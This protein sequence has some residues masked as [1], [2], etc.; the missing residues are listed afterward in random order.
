[1]KKMLAI[2]V[3]LVL[4]LTAACALGEAPAADPLHAHLE[5][6]NET[7]YTLANLDYG[8]MTPKDPAMAKIFVDLL[9]DMTIKPVTTEAPDGIYVVLSFPEENTRFDFFLANPEK[10]LFRYVKADGTEEM[11]EATVPEGRADIADLMSSWAY[12]VADELGLVPPVTAKLPDPGWILDSVNGKVWMDDR[13]TLEVFLEDTDNYKVLITWGSSAT[14]AVEWTY[15]C[16][17]NAENQTLCAAHMIRDS[18]VYD[19]QGNES[20]TTV[21]E[22]DV[23]TVF[24]LNADGKVVITNAGDEQL[25]GKTFEAVPAEQAE[26]AWT[27][28]ES[29][30][31]TEE[32]QAK[33][34]AAMAHLMGAK[35]TP[36]AYL[37]TDG[38]A[39]CFFC[40][41]EAVVP[42]PVPRYTL[43]Y[44][45]DS[46][47]QNIYDV[48]VENHAEK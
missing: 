21:E 46:G 48:W 23:Q 12:S 5:K 25:D 47:G 16:A 44:I 29:N 17:Y 8:E 18:L 26:S 28:P 9:N 41:S 42:N 24:A 39:D 15:G 11:Y 13:A 20:R 32:L 35:H 4:A 14:E 38:T 30:A 10:N 6:L 31:V 27:S 1:M 37:G 33:F 19:E 3:S 22:K 40:R 7:P 34:D 2:I 45:K 36:L 43:V